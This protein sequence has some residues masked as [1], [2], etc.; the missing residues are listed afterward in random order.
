ML[1]RARLIGI[2]TRLGIGIQ[3]DPD[4]CFCTD[5]TWIPGL[6][7]KQTP[8]MMEAAIS[9]LLEWEAATFPK[10]LMLEHLTVLRTGDLGEVLAAPELQWYCYFMTCGKSLADVG[11]E[12]ASRDAFCALENCPTC[13]SAKLTNRACCRC[14]RLPY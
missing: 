11:R 3:F 2:C 13:Q 12:I 5:A 4:G 6:T 1:T 7:D 10:A 14:P 8:E 9:L